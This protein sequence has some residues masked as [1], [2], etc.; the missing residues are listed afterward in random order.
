MFFQQDGHLEM[1][2]LGEISLTD[3]ILFDQ[4]V[5]CVHMFLWKDEVPVNGENLLQSTQV[6]AINTWASSGKTKRDA[7]GVI[8]SWRSVIR[9][10]QIVS[11]SLK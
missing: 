3:G 10:Y 8:Y 7:H 11:V 9:C 6:E 4:V 1:T 5:H 2:D